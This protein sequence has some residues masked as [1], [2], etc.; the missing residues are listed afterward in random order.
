MHWDTFMFRSQKDSSYLSQ[1]SKMAGI[2][3]LPNLMGSNL[4]VGMEGSPPSS[5]PATQLNILDAVQG[6]RDRLCLLQHGS[7]RRGGW[8]G[9]LIHSISSIWPLSHF[10][11]IQFIHYCCCPRISNIRFQ[12]Q[13]SYSHGHCEEG[14][15]LALPSQ[16]GSHLQ[17]VIFWSI[18]DFLHPQCLFFFPSNPTVLFM[19]IKI[20]EETNDKVAK[21]FDII[22]KPV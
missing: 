8:Q 20:F 22:N 6:N 1:Y 17:T 15:S 18:C 19:D 14:N 13:L 3:S 12:S 11:P 4:P 9:L 16:E 7:D 5:A 21:T 2:R 10:T